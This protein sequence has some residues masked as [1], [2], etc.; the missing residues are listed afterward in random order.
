MTLLSPSFAASQRTLGLLTIIGNMEIL[1]LAGTTG[2]ELDTAFQSSIP[3][4]SRSWRSVAAQCPVS[5]SIIHLCSMAS[6]SSSSSADGGERKTPLSLLS[7]TDTG[8]C[9]DDSITDKGGQVVRTTSAD[10]AILTSRSL[11]AS[12]LTSQMGQSVAGTMLTLKHSFQGLTSMDFLNRNGS[13][14]GLPLIG[15]P[16]RAI[17][18]SDDSEKQD[19]SIDTIMSSSSSIRLKEVVVPFFDYAS[20]SD[21]SSL[22]S[23]LGGGQ[24][25]R[26][27]VGVYRWPNSPT[28]LRPVPAATEDQRLPAPTF[29]FHCE[30]PHD[31]ITKLDSSSDL[32]CGIQAARIGYGGL[33]DGQLMLL[34]QDLIGLDIRYCPRTTITSAFSEAQDSLLASSLKELQSTNVLLASGEKSHDDDRIGKGDCWV[35]FRANMKQPSGFMKRSARSSTTQRVAKVPDIPY[36]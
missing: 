12:Q 1:S 18:D 17:D 9:V 16:D 35:E 21:G 11:L 5:G 14:G 13:S 8:H 22:L 19:I 3:G 32:G 7:I 25:Q 36:E 28:Y 26:P 27:A 34:H 33:G 29:V 24:L 4:L 6:S 10:M 31:A 2:D 20:Y 15:L 23:R 30:S